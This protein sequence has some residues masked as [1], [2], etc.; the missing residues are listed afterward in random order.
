MPVWGEQLERDY[1]QLKAGYDLVGARIDTIVTFLE[2]IQ[3]LS[4]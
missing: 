1:A 3:R 2:A 4:R